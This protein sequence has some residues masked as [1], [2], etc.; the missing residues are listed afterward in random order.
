[1]VVVRGNG[2]IVAG[3]N[4]VVHGNNCVVANGVA[5]NCVVGNGKV[6]AERRLVDRVDAI[7]LDGPISLI[8]SRGASQFV[9]VTAD[10]NILPLVITRTS[11]TRLHIECSANFTTQNEILVEIEMPSLSAFT[12]K[13]TGNAEIADIEQPS[14]HVNL[15]G[16]G[17]IK[18]A[19]RVEH[20]TAELNGSGDIRA[21][22]LKAKTASLSLN[23][24]GDIRAHASTSVKARL[25][26]SGDIE[27]SGAPAQKD[28]KICGSG[29]IYFD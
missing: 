21:N 11:G 23:G 12:T 3:G 10:E 2:N 19:G 13:G 8:F 14:L 24:S 26:G 28:C 16:S 5:M 1:M 27:V 22:S 6:K 20:F 9:R 15:V 18:I 29:D 17:R 25:N 4:V 7:V